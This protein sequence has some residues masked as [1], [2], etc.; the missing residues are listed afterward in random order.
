MV[1]QGSS[2]LNHSASPAEGHVVAPDLPRRYLTILAQAADQLLA[3]T[4]SAAMVEQ[5]FAL[6]QSELRLDAFF[7][8]RFDGDRLFLE[9]SSGLTEE[10]HAICASLE[11]GQ[12]VCGCVARDREREHVMAIQT[13]ADPRTAIVREIGL[14]AYACTPLLYGDELLGTLSFGRRWSE[15]FTAE[16][17]QLLYTLCHYVALAKYRLRAEA[18]LREGIATR[19]RLLAELNHRVRN[20]L[21]VAVAAVR[22]EIAEVEDGSSRATIE[23]AA[24][25]VQLIAAAH[26]GLYRDGKSENVSIASLLSEVGELIAD[27]PFR[28]E[29]DD[30]IALPIERAVSLSLLL[31][32][33]LSGYAASPEVVT[34]ATTTTGVSISLPHDGSDTFAPGR[35]ASALLRQLQAHLSLDGGNLE[36]SIPL[37]HAA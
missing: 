22:S 35:F 36:L 30:S 7:N 16:E 29:C 26:R 21:Q 28:I 15:S 34:V 4:D 11:L 37:S 32:A 17:L 3:A 6:I 19:D 9:A 24:D 14:D 8:Y 33:L 10:Q 25:R 20:S 31:H 1:S 23:R 5:L 27:E 12:A 13:S 18:A 2:R